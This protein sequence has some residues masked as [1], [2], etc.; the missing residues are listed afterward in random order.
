MDVLLSNDDVR[1]GGVGFI[2][3]YGRGLLSSSSVALLYRN[4]LCGSCTLVVMCVAL[5]SNCDVW[6][7]LISTCGGGVHLVVAVVLHSNC[8]IW[9]EMEPL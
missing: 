2:S 1:G 5:F 4:D 9:G 8:D 7:G 3:S 6:G